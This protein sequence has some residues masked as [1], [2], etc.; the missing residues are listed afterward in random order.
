[1]L[2]RNIIPA[3]AEA[4]S[5]KRFRDCLRRHGKKIKMAV[6]RNR[7]WNKEFIWIFNSAFFCNPR[8]IINRHTSIT[9]FSMLFCKNASAYIASHL[10]AV[11]TLPDVLRAKLV[12]NLPKYQWVDFTDLD[13]LFFVF[14]LLQYNTPGN[15]SDYVH[16][17]GRTAR[18][19]LQ[20]NALL[21]LTPAEVG[22]VDFFYFLFFS[23]NGILLCRWNDLFSPVY[24]S[25]LFV[26]FVFRSNT[27]KL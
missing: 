8:D 1:M 22:L 5:C 14:C 24:L 3:T 27:W 13:F 21:F 2:Q 4:Q 23:E 18:I 9:C 26:L 11:Q 16:R 12:P 19:G 25:Q 17:V 20:G 7:K 10:V 6:T 15:P